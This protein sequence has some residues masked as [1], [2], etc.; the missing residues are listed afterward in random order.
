MKSNNQAK[1]IETFEN[2]I[3]CARKSGD[4]MPGNEM[5]RYLTGIRISRD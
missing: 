5:E 4:M 1:A 3:E 2:G